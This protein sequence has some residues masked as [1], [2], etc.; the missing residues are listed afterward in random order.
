MPLTWKPAV[1]ASPAKVQPPLTAYWRAASTSPAAQVSGMTGMAV[2]LPVRT[3][4][5]NERPAAAAMDAG[6]MK[7][8]VEPPPPGVK[9]P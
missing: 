4:A 8:S 7:A 1:V 2:Q 9:Q 5:R 6:T 3:P